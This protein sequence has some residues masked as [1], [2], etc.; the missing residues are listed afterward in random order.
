MTRAFLAL[1]TIVVAAALNGCRGGGQ[2]SGPPPSGADT[3]KIPFNDM[4]STQR[5]LGFDGGLY[6]GGNAMPAVHLGQ[7]PVP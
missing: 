7:P 2:S 6:P 3:T 5:Y 1:G 4:V